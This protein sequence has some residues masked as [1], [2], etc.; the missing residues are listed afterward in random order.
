MSESVVVLN[1]S[2]KT[3]ITNPVLNTEVTN[4][5]NVVLNTPDS[6]PIGTVQDSGG[7]YR[8]LV[9]TDSTTIASN[10]LPKTDAFGRYRVSSPTSIFDSK[11]VFDHQ[12]L[13]WDIHTEGTASVVYDNSRAS[14]ILHSGTSNGSRA[15]RQTKRY[16]N[17][18]P[19]KSQLVFITFNFNGGSEGTTKSVGYYDNS[20]GIYLSLNG[21]QISIVKRSSVPGNGANQATPQ[22]SW[23][24]DRLD[25]TGPSGK[26]LDPTKVMILVIDFEWL[27]VGSVRVGFDFG[28][29]IIYAHKMYHANVISSVYM[30]TPN[31]PVRYEIM[32]SVNGADSILEAICCSVQSEG[33][34]NPLGVQR[35]ASRGIVGGTMTA[36]MQSMFSIRLKSA[37]NRATVFPLNGTVITTD[38][39]VNY[40][41]QLILNPTFSSVPTWSPVTNSP[42]E[43]SLTVTPVTGGTI[44]SEFYGIAATPGKSGAATVTTTADLTS[45]LALAS[46]YSGTA[47]ILTLA[48]QKIS[49]NPNNGAMYAMIDW[50]ELL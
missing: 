42:I 31:L 5:P 6:H 35:T 23:N 1:P 2:F 49:G 20:D 47:D 22:G 33:G 4:S 36:G 15:V 40:F 18:Q 7:N 16:F 44:L 29:E 3:E 48:V 45:V 11:Q 30:R 24:L 13:L 28:G 8:L 37:Y 21:N 12:P 34:A 38:T 26:T 46:N 17:Y 43:S 39:G 50:L 32:K 14:S 9:S 41:G 19:G 10:D 25:G 27:G